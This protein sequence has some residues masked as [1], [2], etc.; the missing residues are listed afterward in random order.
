MYQQL[1]KWERKHRGKFS[2]LLY[3]SDEFGEQELPSAE[4]PGFVSQYL[5]INTDGSCCH[6]MAKVEVNG[7]RA[8]KCWQSLKQAFPGDVE[9]NFDAMFLVDQEGIPVGRYSTSDLKR[10]DADLAYLVNLKA[11]E[12]PN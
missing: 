11:G 2:I 10:A 3:P 8:D 7:K 9:W 6:L 1:I 4:I 12:E 5:P